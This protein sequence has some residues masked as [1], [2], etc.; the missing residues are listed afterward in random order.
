MSAGTT[1][2]ATAAPTGTTGAEPTIEGFTAPGFEAVRAAFEENFASRGEVGASVGVVVDGRTVVDLWGGVADPAT[3]RAWQRD[4]TTLVYSVTKG[5][6]SVL[7]HVLAQRGTLDLDAPVAEYWPEFA[8]QGKGRVTVRQ[9]VSHQVGLPAVDTRLSL[10]QLL[11]GHSVAEALAAQPPLWEPGTAHGYHALTFGWLVAEL[12]RRATGRE[13][14]ELVQELLAEPLG[15]TLWV[16]LPSDAGADVA[17]LVDGVPDPA[18]FAAMDPAAQEAMLKFREIIADPESLFARVLST[19]GALPTP[20]AAAWNDP[21]VRAT[22]L[23][24]ASGIT[25]GRSLARLYGACVAEV[26]GIRLLDPDVVDRARTELVF[27]ADQ[28]LMSPTRFGTGFMLHHDGMA[29]LSDASFGHT[30]AGGALAFADV[31]ARVGFGYAQNL[32]GANPV[33]LRSAALVAAVR[34]SL[35]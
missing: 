13:F 2:Q 12:V 21:R 3:G 22:A 29:M 31:D 24:A 8:Q 17:T 18:L 30:G 32:L 10:E 14:G 28:V 4:T 11:D 16:G 35:G 7:L 15:L 26:D 20:D 27:G 6:S 9:L 25:N 33:E 19:N 1:G 23:P 34:D 5:I